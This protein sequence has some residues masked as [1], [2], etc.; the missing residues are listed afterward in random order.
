M[1]VR[2]H[3]H[4]PAALLPGKEPRYPLDKEAGWSPE[5]AVWTLWRKE[6]IPSFR[7]LNPCRPARSLVTILSYHGFMSIAKETNMR[8]CANMRLCMDSASRW[9]T[10]SEIA[11]NVSSW[12]DHMTV[13]LF[14]LEACVAC[15]GRCWNTFEISELL[16]L[17]D[18][19]DKVKD[20]YLFIYSVR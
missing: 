2:G 8:L 17:S 15:E 19:T 13:L 3:I 4:P 18:I 9:Y 1:E 12:C 16:N 11:A 10:L 14:P 5:P 20:I 6:K 7:Y